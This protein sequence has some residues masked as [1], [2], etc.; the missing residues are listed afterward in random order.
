[1]AG[2]SGAGYETISEDRVWCY[3][4]YGLTIDTGGIKWRPEVRLDSAEQNGDELQ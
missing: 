2:G 1:M 3:R 4:V